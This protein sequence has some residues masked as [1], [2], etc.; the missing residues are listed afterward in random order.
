MFL[1]V[2]CFL[3]F[4]NLF[5]AEEEE[6]RRTKKEVFYETKFNRRR[7]RVREYDL[8]SR[9]WL[10]NNR[11]ATAVLCCRSLLLL[12]YARRRFLSFSISREIRVVCEYGSFTYRWI[13]NRGRCI[14]K[15][16]CSRSNLGA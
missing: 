7:K 5:S 12:R 11:L 13:G 9:D 2:T 15:P 3:C 8:V 1:K 16:V 4:A 14:P 6:D 10:I